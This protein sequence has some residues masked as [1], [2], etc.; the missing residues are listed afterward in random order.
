MKRD[1]LA[2]PILLLLLTV[3][4]PSLGV[5]WMMREAVRNERAATNQRLHEAYRLQLDQA[6]EKLKD[7]WDMRH[8][9]LSGLVTASRPDL[10][11]A[12][13]VKN[14]AADSVVLCNDSGEVVYPETDIVPERIETNN[15]PR[16]QAANRLEFV[17]GRYQEAADAY[18]ELIEDSDSSANAYTVFLPKRDVWRKPAI[19]KEPLTLLK[20]CRSTRLLTLVANPFDVRRCCECL[21][22]RKKIRTVGGML[23][24]NSSYDF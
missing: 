23:P 11:F 5:V 20:V 22:L 21:N 24:S 7:R 8:S 13:M 9:K 18:G 1:R 19:E 12:T 16:W 10:S 17:L 2:W 3:L 6:A 15:D 4:I 14:L